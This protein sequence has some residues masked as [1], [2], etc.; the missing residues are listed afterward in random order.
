MLV[1]SFYE[2]QVFFKVKKTLQKQTLF[3]ARPCISRQVCAG[4]PFLWALFWRLSWATG[5][6]A[7]TIQQGGW[8][9]KNFQQLTILSWV[10]AFEIELQIILIHYGKFFFFF[11]SFFTSNTHILI[12]LYQVCSIMNWL[13]GIALS[14]QSYQCSGSSIC[15]SSFYTFIINTKKSS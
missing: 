10:S 4:A 15:A 7:T 9:S 6:R 1:F 5:N 14:E 8:E 2:N 12:F 3:T 11:I 13:L